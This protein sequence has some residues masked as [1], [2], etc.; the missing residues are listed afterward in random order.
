MKFSMTEINKKPFRRRASERDKARKYP[1]EGRRRFIALATCQGLRE[2]IVLLVMMII[3]L[4]GMA[5]QADTSSVQIEQYMQ[6]AAQN[7]PGLKAEYRQYLSAL[8]QS[9]QVSTLPDPELS[10]GYFINPIETRIGPQQA[11]F[12]ITQMFPWFG[13]LDAR[14]NA[15]TQ[16]AKAKF[17]A[18]QDVR[19][20]LFYEV[21]KS[22]YN[23][24]KI[25][26]VIR[27]LEENI[28]LLDIFESLA[29]QEYETNQVGQADVLRVQIEKEDLKSRLELQKDNR[30]VAL[31]EFNELL[32]RQ[33]DSKVVTPD[34][35]QKKVLKMSKNELEHVAMRQNPQLS[36]IDFEASSARSSI[37]AAQKE[38]MPKFG[39]GIDYMITGERDMALT[40]NGQDAILARMGIQI[41]LYRK[42]YRAKEKQAQIQLRSVQDRQQA[43]ENRLLTQLSKA[44]RNYN[45]GQR[46]LNLY[47]DIQIQR[48][49]QT[50][51]I[52]T[53][54]YA[55]S[56]TDFDEL[57][58]LQR[59]LLDYELAQQQ[60]LVDLNTAVARIEYLYGKHNTNPK[61]I[62]LE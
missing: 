13:T 6:Q 15:A 33:S 45:D 46:R 53:E 28:E 27:I 44:L 22:W 11:R 5:Q 31:Q 32:N 7:N 14:G 49:Q 58:R 19:N 30:Q 18:F 20:K 56:A 43:T 35:L 54:Q 26:Q 17:E 37:K 60:A 24:Y 41:P 62:E 52:L 47:K 48:T 25:E 59:K 1:F 21:Q 40:D 3:P 8:Q 29:M 16:Q 57:L 61:E 9:P 42:K 55:T 36:K 2:M 10:F 34:S 38:G 39:V 23:L 12:G 51:D 50:I 4:F